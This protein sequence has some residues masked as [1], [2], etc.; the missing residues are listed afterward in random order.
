MFGR[1]LQTTEVGYADEI[2][3]AASLLMGQADQKR[4]VVLVR[5]LTY[6]RRVASAKDLVRDRELD[7]F[8]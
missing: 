6:Y 4:P 8:R 7:M 5:G 2:A 1:A 3:A